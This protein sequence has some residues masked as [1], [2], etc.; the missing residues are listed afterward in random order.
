[1]EMCITLYYVLQYSDYKSNQTGHDILFGCSG[2]LKCDWFN[3]IIKVVTEI[4]AP[5]FDC[6]SLR[7][8]DLSFVIHMY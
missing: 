8:C 7:P 3:K 1:M 6:N 4:S 5:P 2:Y